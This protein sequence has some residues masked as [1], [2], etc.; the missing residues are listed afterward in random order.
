[1]QSRWPARS[2]ARSCRSNSRPRLRSR[3]MK[4]MRAPWRARGAGRDRACSGGRRDDYRPALHRLLSVPL[5]RAAV[6]HRFI[7]GS[8]AGRSPT[9]T[10]S[11]APARL[12]FE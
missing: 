12:F 1:M 4:M 10:F 7:T 3:A 6:P 9:G 2:D 11:I 8:F 5:L